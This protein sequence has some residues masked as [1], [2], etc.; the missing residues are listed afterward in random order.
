ML[1]GLAM[2]MRMSP[3]FDPADTMSWR[4]ESSATIARPS[5]PLAPTRRMRSRCDSG[6][7][8]LFRWKVWAHGAQASNLGLRAGLSQRRDEVDEV[9]HGDI[10]VDQVPAPALEK[11]PVHDEVAG[12]GR[13]PGARR[14]RRVDRERKIRSLRPGDAMPGRDSGQRYEGR[15]ERLDER[16]PA[17]IER[18]LAKQVRLGRENGIELAAG[19]RGGIGAG[20][21]HAR[22][23]GMGEAGIVGRG[24]T[25]RGSL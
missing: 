17:P 14:H 8:L 2:S 24:R 18:S 1:A 21:L 10:D 6:I 3:D 9:A 23:F 16:F 7:S 12:E 20:D 4:G 5:T 19:K 15:V 22:R 11:P 25:R 13:R